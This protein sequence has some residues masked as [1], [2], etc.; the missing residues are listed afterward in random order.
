MQGPGRAGELVDGDQTGGD[1]RDHQG[2]P[3]PVPQP[4]NP[5][6]RGHHGDTGG[7][8][9]PE[10]H[11]RMPGP[12]PR[13]N[14]GGHTGDRDRRDRHAHGPRA[15]PPPVGPG[16]Q[17]HGGG[18]ADDA[19][20]RQRP[21]E[22]PADL[23]HGR[24]SPRLVDAGGHRASGGVVGIGRDTGPAPRHGGR[25]VGPHHAQR[26]RGEV[27]QLHIALTAGR[28]RGQRPGLDA[29]PG[30]DDRVERRRRRGVGDP[31]DHEPPPVGQDRGDLGDGLVG[32]GGGGH[33]DRV[34]F[35][36]LARRGLLLV[37]GDIGVVLAQLVVVGRGVGVDRG[38][39]ADDDARVDDDDVAGGHR[40][41]QRLQVRAP[42]RQVPLGVGRGQSGAHAD[43]GHAQ[44]LAD[45]DRLLTGPRG[46]GGG[47][48]LLDGQGLDRLGQRPEPG[49]VVVGRV[50]LLQVRE[51]RQRPL[52][53]DRHGT[54]NPRLGH[55]VRIPRRGAPGALPGAQTRP[56]G[57]GARPRPDRPHA[58]RR[59]RALTGQ[60]PQRRRL[61]RADVRPRQARHTD[62]DHTAGLRQVLLALRRRRGGAH[63]G[64]EHRRQQGRAQSPHPPCP[65]RCRAPRRRSHPCSLLPARPLQGPSPPRPDASHA[66]LRARGRR[67]R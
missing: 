34:R 42:E 4:R 66:R 28:R 61:G 45:L 29:V 51:M 31:G 12:P 43:R 37:R 19:Q 1:A 2:G 54:G 9:Q 36:L 57:L 10:R 63:Q 23:G 59:R 55:A 39:I 17:P 52:A 5:G 11:L 6:R 32:L 53:A 16:Q 7:D 13:R 8:D 20:H 33:A 3:A 26:G 24:R 60:V 58:H 56:P 22:L 48:G 35:G 41:G 50:G 49:P 38:L 14:T 62:D 15:L 27:D 65:G 25:H 47:L 40:L 21:V 67:G 46:L 30:V 44:P 64:G 18:D